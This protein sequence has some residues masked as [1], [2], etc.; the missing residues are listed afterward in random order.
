M[1]A[2]AKGLS[3]IGALLLL[4]GCSNPVFDPGPSNTENLIKVRVSPAVFSPDDDGE[5]DQVE[6]RIFPDGDVMAIVWI[7]QKGKVVYSVIPQRGIFRVV[8]DGRD[9]QDR[10]VDRGRYRIY[11]IAEELN[12]WRRQV[13]VLE[14]EVRY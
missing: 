5:T 11:V 14:V 13:E 4:W 10:R 2:S 6:I 1:R 9:Y 3:L 12:N 8:W 7:V